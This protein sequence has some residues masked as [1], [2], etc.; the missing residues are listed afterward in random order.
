MSFV[1]KAVSNLLG[2]TPKAPD[3]PPP[4]PPAPTMQ[5]SAEQLDQAARAQAIASQGGRTS[6]LINGAMGVDDTKNTSKILLGQ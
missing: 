4:P 6:T 1:F 2:L 3:A 5:N